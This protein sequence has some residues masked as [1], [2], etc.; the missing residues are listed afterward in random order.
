[1]IISDLNY[2][3]VSVSVGDVLGGGHH[4]YNAP[5][6]APAPK[7]TPN[8]ASGNLSVTATGNTTNTVGNLVISVT[9]TSSSVY[10]SGSASSS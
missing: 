1:M 10:A 2:L 9:P 7:P 5:A 3:E 6:P 4:R 8:T